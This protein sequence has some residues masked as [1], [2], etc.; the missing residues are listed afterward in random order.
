[1]TDSSVL[2]EYVHTVIREFAIKLDD[3]W[4][5]EHERIDRQLADHEHEILQQAIWAAILAS[6]LVAMAVTAIAAF[7][8]AR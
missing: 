1:M 5:R 7:I 4:M 2:R 3:R 8:L 6:T